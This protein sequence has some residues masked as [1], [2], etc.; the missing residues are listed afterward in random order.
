MLFETELMAELTKIATDDIGKDS[1]DE[2]WDALSLFG[3]ALVDPAQ[4]F[5]DYGTS[6]VITRAIG[7]GVD[8]LTP[9][10]GLEV[11]TSEQLQHPNP[12]P[13][14]WP[15][16]VGES[17]LAGY[18]A[19]YASAANSTAAPP[20][21]FER[22]ARMI[23][24]QAKGV[25]DVRRGNIVQIIP[26]ADPEDEYVVVSLPGAFNTYLLASND[27]RTISFAGKA[28]TVVKVV[29]GG[30][31]VFFS[32]GTA[33]GAVYA[34]A[35]ATDSIVGKIELAAKVRGGVVYAMGAKGWGT[36]VATLPGVYKS[37]TDLLQKEAVNPTYL[38]GSNTYSASATM[39]LLADEEY[40]GKSIVY[41]VGNILEQLAGKQASVHVM[42]TGNTSSPI[43]LRTTGFC[44]RGTHGNPLTR[45]FGG[46][47]TIR[48][49][50][51]ASYDE[52]RLEPGESHTFAVSY[53][54][55]WGDI[56]KPRYLEVDV[57]SGPFL[58]K[59][60]RQAFFLGQPRPVPASFKTE[61]QTITADLGTKAVFT[62]Y[63]QQQ[64]M[65]EP[66]FI[67]MIPTVL[68]V[69]SG[70]VNAT[71][72]TLSY[73]WTVGDGT[74]SVAF[75]L[76]GDP[77][78]E[79]ALQ[80]YDETGACVG[81]VPAKGGRVVQFVAEYNGT[82]ARPQ[83]VEIPDAAGQTY[84][85]KAVL[86]A[87]NSPGPFDVEIVATETPVRPAVLA[88]TPSKLSVVTR[89]GY[90]VHVPV[91]FAEAGE[92]Q[93]LTDVVVTAAP[94]TALG[95]GTT[96]VPVSGAERDFGTL[97][98]D[99]SG[100]T[101]YI[102]AVPPSAPPALF[103]GSVTVTAANAGSQALTVEVQ[104]LPTGDVNEDCRVNILD[105]IFIRNRLGQEVSVGDNWMADANED[106]KINILDLIKVR[107]RLNT[108]CF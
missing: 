44:V 107:G 92:Q 104:V 103:K 91:I 56:L 51:S 99:S 62:A 45:L 89:P 93:P 100:A 6:L 81:N 78:A 106:G 33:A 108:T 43:R 24:G 74:W 58:C 73:T 68:T 83:I 55:P 18:H 60:M 84:T 8:A 96:L 32:G 47:Q 76:Y 67:Q 70:T 21:N 15:W 26:L 16:S 86:V 97:K 82:Q 1:T 61:G 4:A 64:V 39:N 98:A 27:I 17:L 25:E 10:T 37:T 65:E 48:V 90:D 29:A 30:A 52:V 12:E 11:W 105:L 34:G 46:G 102:Y 77:A 42:N 69:G 54:A 53:L 66:E 88:V 2:I 7:A 59:T 40:P 19:D 38:D 57:Y 28:L 5:A 13:A 23:S 22:A 101:E 14:D 41:C 63:G 35:T 85:V 80:V 75:T 94:L 72:T 79:I 20:F 31:V 3:D 49:P 87:S 9:H 71:D 36:D 95:S 50:T